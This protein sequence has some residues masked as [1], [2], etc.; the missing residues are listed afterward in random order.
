VNVVPAAKAPRVNTALPPLPPLP[1]LLPAPPPAPL[2]VIV[3]LVIG[4]VSVYV[5]PVVGVVKLHVVVLSVDDAVD[6]L[7]IIAYQSPDVL[8][9]PARVSVVLPLSVKV[10]D[11]IEGFTVTKDIV[12]AVVVAIP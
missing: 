1:P 11:V 2:T 9:V 10:N 6:P 12:D 8:A 4:C 7:E 3:P 5:V